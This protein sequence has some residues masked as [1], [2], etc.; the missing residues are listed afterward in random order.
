M[1][2]PAALPEACVLGFGHDE[3]LGLGPALCALLI[4]GERGAAAAARGLGR[5]SGSGCT[6]AGEDAHLRS[7]QRRRTLSPWPKA[8]PSHSWALRSP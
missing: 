3:V 8:W 5:G 2:S 4:N 7:H 6:R 1:V